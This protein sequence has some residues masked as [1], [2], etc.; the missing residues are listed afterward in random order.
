MKIIDCREPHHFP[1]PLC[2]LW[3]GSYKRFSD[4]VQMQNSSPK[5]NI[6]TQGSKFLI[7]ATKPACNSGEVLKLTSL[8]LQCKLYACCTIAVSSHQKSIGALQFIVLFHHMLGGQLPP[9]LTS[10]VV[11][12][13][14]WFKSVLFLP[15]RLSEG[16]ILDQD[17]GLHLF[18]TESD[19]ERAKEG[20]EPQ[21]DYEAGSQYLRKMLLLCSVQLRLQPSEVL[22]NWYH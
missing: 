1:P 13:G 14:S 17:P 6:F 2:R 9:T 22:Q 15:Q 19:P 10:T 18:N 11:H 20:R 12:F 8:L 3:P 21:Q 4:W 16:E 5:T 7:S